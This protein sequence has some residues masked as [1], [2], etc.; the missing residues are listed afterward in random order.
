MSLDPH[1][2]DV[3]TAIEGHQD[4]AVTPAGVLFDMLQRDAA[5][6]RDAVGYN[7]RHEIDVSQHEAFAA[8][9]RSC[10]RCRTP[11]RLPPASAS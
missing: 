3:R 4:V 10:I 6:T 8:A 2:P 11:S 7:F 1:N 5:W 9:G